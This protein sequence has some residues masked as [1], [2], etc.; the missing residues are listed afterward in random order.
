MASEASA[1]Y[2]ARYFFLKTKAINRNVAQ[3][4][5]AENIRRKKQCEH[6]SYAQNNLCPQDL[7]IKHVQENAGRFCAYRVE[8]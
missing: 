3:T 8:K 7:F 1:S 4:L 2:A 5:V 6:V